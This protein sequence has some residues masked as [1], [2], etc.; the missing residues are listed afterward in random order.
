MTDTTTIRRHATLVDRMAQK[1]GLD[2]EQ[3]VLE[4]QLDPDSLCDAV[5]D[6]TG[7][8]DPDGCTVWLDTPASQTDAAP[9]MCRNR[10]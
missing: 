5:L 6:C 4:G 2:L 8:S 1:L 3:K 10:I 7:C 9:S